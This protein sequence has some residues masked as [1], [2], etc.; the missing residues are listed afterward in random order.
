MED[1][2]KHIFYAHS[3]NGHTS[4]QSYEAHIDGMCALAVK[5]VTSAYVYFPD[6]DLATENIIIV[7]N[8]GEF[9][10]LGKLHPFN[11]LHLGSD[12]NEK[13]PIPA[14]W[15]AGVASLLSLQSEAAILINGSHL[16]LFSCKEE[17]KK[18]NQFLRNENVSKETDFVLDKLLEK[19][20]SICGNREIEKISFRKETT[21]LMRRINLSCLVDADYTDTSNHYY[22]GYLDFSIPHPHWGRRIEL[23]DH[24]VEELTKTTPD[25]E[26]NSI[27]RALYDACKRYKGKSGIVVNDASVGNAKT[28]ACL[29]LAL[30][31]ANR[32]SCRHVIYVEPR[33]SII[34]EVVNAIRSAIMFKGENPDAA[35][36]ENHHQVEFMD[37]RFRHL[38]R[39]WMSPFIVTTSVQFIETISGNSGNRLRKLH[40]LPGSVIIIDEAHLLART[41]EWPIVWEWLQELT[42]NWGCHIILSSGSLP[43]VWEMKQLVG[44]IYD[45]PNVIPRELSIRMDNLEK[46]R[47]VYK[48]NPNPLMLSELIDFVLENKPPYIIVMDTVQAAAVTSYGL[49]QRGVDALHLST[50]LTPE[51]REEVIK[52]VKEKLKINKGKWALVCTS[53]AETGLNFDGF[54]TAFRQRSSVPSLLQLG[55]RSNREALLSQSVVWDFV[56]A[57]PLL[58]QNWAL[59]DQRSLL[60]NIL[61]RNWLNNRS[62]GDI[63][64]EALRLELM[65]PD[66]LLSAKDLLKLERSLC[67]PEVAEKCKPINDDHVTV[68]IDPTILQKIRQEEVVS[69]TDLVRKSVSMWKKTAENLC[70]PKIDGGDVYYWDRRYDPDFLGYMTD[71]VPLL[72][73]GVQMNAFFV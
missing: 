23:L 32:F 47:V 20:R 5:N 17:R 61:Q 22:P 69:V 3:A 64:T 54:R 10:D 70:V 44:K 43:K 39:G 51:D 28:L 29:R 62:A 1:M 68:V 24:Y 38:S 37:K 52:R 58:T 15:D 27:R 48:S 59:K 11:Q 49:K 50:A 34:T 67:Y 7:S 19:H 55:G 2:N 9:H 30:G 60:S 73:S 14:H 18:G 12:S 31:I 8:A 33:I 36:A 16:G 6:R 53:C 4:P 72:I 35:V 42:N 71:V 13:L 46:V 63:M 21:G 40:N 65:T 66:V 26:R 41:Q 45:V 56:C 57:D 25:T